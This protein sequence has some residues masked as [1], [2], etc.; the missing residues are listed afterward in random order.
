MA[1]L[2]ISQYIIVGLFFAGII[3][4]TFCCI[5]GK[6]KVCPERGNTSENR[7]TPNRETAIQVNSNY[8]DDENRNTKVDIDLPPSYDELFSN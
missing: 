1:T 6:R 4:G 8:E 2:E 3:I 5:Y 7:E